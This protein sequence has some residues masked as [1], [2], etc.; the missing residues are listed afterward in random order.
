[1]TTERS[2]VTYAQFYPSDWRSGCLD[3]NLEEEGLYIRCCA[4]MYDTGQPI[5]GDDS[6]A[7][8]LLRVNVLKYVKVMGSLVDKGK[9]IRAQGVLINERVFREIDKFRT[10]RAA[11][12]AAARRREANRKTL[13]RQI[14]ETVKGGIL[15]RQPE[16]TPH[17]THPQTPHLTPGVNPPSLLGGNPPGSQNATPPVGSKNINENNGSGADDCQ[18]KTTD[19]PQAPPALRIQNPES[20][21]EEQTN[22]QIIDHGARVARAPDGGDGEGVLDP[23]L[24][25][26]AR[27]L[28]VMFG[29]DTDPDTDRGLEVAVRWAETYSLDDVLD[30]A[31]DLHARKSD[32]TEHKPVSERLFAE[33][34]RRSRHNR[35]V[36]NAPVVAVEK[37]PPPTLKPGPLAEGYVVT[38]RL[39]IELV[40]GV[41]AEW[42]ERFGGHEGILDDTLIEISGKIRP[43]SPT[44]VTVQIDS[45]LAAVARDQKSSDKR[46]QKA[47]SERERARQ[48]PTKTAPDGVVETTAQRLERMALAMEKGGKS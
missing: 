32:R 21:I 37:P 31:L 5:P 43:N 48:R 34:V 45:L 27:L 44:P 36:R 29:S 26:S 39:R 12:E 10:N 28:A 33:Y 24:A 11:R 25:S 41:R 3:L 6:H 47:A 38:D 16:T 17:L 46:Y 40:N 7:A 2:G 1:M 13:E 42:L 23:R 8:R 15:R 30:A 18:T 22:K 9:M 14:S 20:R 4:W 19:L 35:E